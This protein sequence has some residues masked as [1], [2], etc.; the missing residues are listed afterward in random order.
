[1][2]LNPKMT[3]SDLQRYPWNLYLI[4][5][6]ED[7]VIFLGL[8]VF[9]SDNSFMFTCSFRITVV[10]KPQLKTISLMYYKHLY[11]ICIFDL[12]KLLRVPLWI[13]NCHLCMEG[14]L[15]LLESPPLMAFPLWTKFCGISFDINIIIS[16]S[17]Q[18][19]V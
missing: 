17:L 5:N 18:P 11:Q 14:H 10:E 12:T 13:G 15:K 2:T 6:V 1:M 7:I 8:K 16:N 3:Q 9:N 19:R 4:N